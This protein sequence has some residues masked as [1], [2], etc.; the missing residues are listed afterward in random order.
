MQLLSTT[1]TEQSGTALNGH[2]LLF[3]FKTQLFDTKWLPL[4][5]LWPIPS[6]QDRYFHITLSLWFGEHIDINYGFG[7]CFLS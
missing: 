1:K 7:Q 3:F 2:P 4:D 5:L 6:T